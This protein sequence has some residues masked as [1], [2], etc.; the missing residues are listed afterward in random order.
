MRTK[1]GIEQV[2]YDFTGGVDGSVPYGVIL[3]SDGNLYGITV[4]G[5]IG[6]GTVFKLTP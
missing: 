1:K 5:G 6:Y 4:G 3:D 2:I